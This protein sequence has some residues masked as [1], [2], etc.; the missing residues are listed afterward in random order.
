MQ[1]NFAHN[2]VNCGANPMKLGDA[3]NVIRRTRTDRVDRYLSC[4]WIYSTRLKTLL[5]S[6]FWQLSHGAR[7]IEF[8][9]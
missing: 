6:E 8:D 7:S 5:G 4:M 3:L 2:E 9:K 1:L